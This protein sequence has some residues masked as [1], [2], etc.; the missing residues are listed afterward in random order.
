MV[1]FAANNI[2]IFFLVLVRTVTTSGRIFIQE[3][4][5]PSTPSKI[6][7]SRDGSCA[8]TM[9]VMAC[10]LMP[11]FQATCLIIL[12]ARSMFGLGRCHPNCTRIKKASRSL[13]FG[14]LNSRRKMKAEQFYALVN[15]FSELGKHVNKNIAPT[16]LFHNTILAPFSTPLT[17]KSKQASQVLLEV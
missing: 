6:K 9:L 10:S 13:H 15:V 14:N 11:S 12:K 17:R 3:P 1:V 2:T 5:S 16:K 8:K 4:T 7:T